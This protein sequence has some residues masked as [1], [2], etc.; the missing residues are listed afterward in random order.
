VKEMQQYHSAL[1]V[2]GMTLSPVIDDHSLV[3]Q[4]IVDLALQLPN[5]FV[6]R[7]MKPYKG[8]SY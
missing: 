1:L 5:S 8:T 3:P 6:V 4:A 2:A 7:L